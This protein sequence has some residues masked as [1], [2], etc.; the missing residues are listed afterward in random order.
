LK[1]QRTDKN[2]RHLVPAPVREGGG[3]SDVNQESEAWG[4]FNNVMGKVNI[5]KNRKGEKCLRRGELIF[6]F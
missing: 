5:K 3:I 6:F 4:G 1:A 2:D